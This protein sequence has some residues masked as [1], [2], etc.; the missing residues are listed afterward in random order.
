MKD[1]LS[2]LAGCATQPA[3]PS[4]KGRR[5]WGESG[6]ANDEGLY[7]GGEVNFQSLPGK[8]DLF[9]DSRLTNANSTCR[10]EACKCCWGALTNGSQE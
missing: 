7:R 5:E 2:R 6:T 3:G 9:A 4:T 1:C 10:L 8:C